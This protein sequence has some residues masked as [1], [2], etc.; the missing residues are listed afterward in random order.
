MHHHG[1]I[2][3]KW[4]WPCGY[5]TYTFK[6]V[7]R[8]HH[9]HYQ[10][11][12]YLYQSKYWCWDKLVGKCARGTPLLVTW[13][14]ALPRSHRAVARNTS[15]HIAI[16][17]QSP[18]CRHWH[19][20]HNPSASHYWLLH[21]PCSFVHQYIMTDGQPLCTY[22]CMCV[23]APISNLRLMPRPPWQPHTPHYTHHTW[24]SLQHTPP[25]CI[26]AQGLANCCFS[27]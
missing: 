27:L 25:L 18:P 20:N 21:K 13:W 15:T 22:V 6:G 19:H 24:W 10:Q 11:G 14:K 3:N 16:S 7:D 1:G 8:H 9:H 12:T 17:N 2:H 5:L 4:G 23:F 26:D